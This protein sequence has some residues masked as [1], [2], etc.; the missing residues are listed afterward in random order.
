MLISAALMCLSLNVYH[1]ARGE[2]L[3]GQFAVANVT[4]NRAKTED[5]VCKTV[6][7]P[8]QF[9]WTAHKTREGKPSIHEPKA[10]KIAQRVAYLVMRGGF[11][12]V[13]N[14]ATMYHATYTSPHLDGRWRKDRIRRVTMIGN[15]I[16]Y[17]QTG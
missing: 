13:T 17:A 4:M 14:G 8:N 10:W 2:S 1:E 3:E 6:Y 15:H 12:D 11:W 5:N 9:S 7:A 16:F